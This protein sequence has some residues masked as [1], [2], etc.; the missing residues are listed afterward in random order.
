MLG[1]QHS[2]GNLVGIVAA[3]RAIIKGDIE[4]KE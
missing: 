3:G 4:L 1:E 2:A